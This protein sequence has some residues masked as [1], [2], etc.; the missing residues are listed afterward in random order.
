M[1]LACG[2]SHYSTA[3]FHLFNHALF[4][5]LLFLSAGSIIHGVCD[6]QDLRRIGGLLRI[7]PIAFIMLFIGNIALTGIPFFTGFY[8]KDAILEI[9]AANGTFIGIMAFLLGSIAAG[10]TSYYSARLAFVVFLNS[11]NAYK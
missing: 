2:L 8:S 11:P 6:E 1:V 9:A 3:L 5:A 7:F 4:K 10:F